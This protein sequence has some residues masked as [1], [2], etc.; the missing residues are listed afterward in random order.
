MRKAAF[1]RWFRDEKKLKQVALPKRQLGRPY[2]PT[3]SNAWALSIFLTKVC[4]TKGAS[5][6]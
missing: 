1:T 5:R 2:Q 3:F 4:Q 6:R